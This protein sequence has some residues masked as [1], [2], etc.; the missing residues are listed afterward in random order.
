MYHHLHHQPSEAVVVAV[1]VSWRQKLASDHGAM[2]C[3]CA[4]V[5]VKQSPMHWDGLAPA[6]LET[7][8][9]AIHSQV[10]ALMH[11]CQWL[12]LARHHHLPRRLRTHFVTDLSVL[13]VHA[14]G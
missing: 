9:T 10:H 8:A 7:L 11:A 6:Q 4:R 1:A 14:V 12:F 13:S 2:G 5:Q 3:V